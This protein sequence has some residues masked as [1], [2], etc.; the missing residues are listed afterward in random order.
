MQNEKILNDLMEEA[1]RSGA[2]EDSP[3]MKLL[4]I[5]MGLEYRIKVLETKPDPIPMFSG[6]PITPIMN[7]MTTNERREKM[8]LPP[9]EASREL[10][11]NERSIYDHLVSK[12]CGLKEAAAIAREV[13]EI[14][15][16]E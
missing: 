5:I 7:F 15:H 10:N 4:H 6:I 1:C 2:G 12:G 16:G 3:Y 9:L 13:E 8:G 14:T 11:E